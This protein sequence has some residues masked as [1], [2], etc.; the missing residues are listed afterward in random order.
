MESDTMRRLALLGCWLALAVVGRTTAAEVA[1]RELAPA[2]KE[3]AKAW[4]QQLGDRN[5]KVRERAATQLL[6]LGRQAQPV[7]EEGARDA[8]AEVRRRCN[9]LLRTA[10]RTDTEVALEEYL[11][12]KDS[13]RLLKLP[14]W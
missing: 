10:L 13:A 3:K 7:L 1:A 9:V 5:F 14:S 8:D 11:A 2:E 6:R 4:V 12:N